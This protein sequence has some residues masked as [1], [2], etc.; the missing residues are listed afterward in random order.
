MGARDCGPQTNSGRDARVVAM[1]PDQPAPGQPA[2][3]QPAPGQPDAEPKL[4]G[5][6]PVHARLPPESRA[7]RSLTDRS[8]T[9]RP[10][11]DR[12]TPEEIR[13]DGA[14]VYPEPERGPRIW[15]RVVGVLI[16]LLGAGGAWV[17]Q[18]PGWLQD[19]VGGLFPGTASHDTETARIDALEARVARLE[20]RPPPTDVAPLVTSL[21]QRLDALEKRVDAAAPASADVRPLVARLDA[22][23]ARVA[24]SVAPSGRGVPPPAASAPT[25]VPVGPD[26]RPLVARI[27]ALEKTAAEHTVE[28]AKVDA[29]A[30]KI[31][32][33]ASH[34]PAAEFRGR[35]EEVTHQLNDLSASYTKQTEAADHA[36]RLARLD[37]AEIALASGHALG[38]IANAPPALARFATAAPPTE[39]ALRLRFGPIAQEA[40]KVSR[41]DTEG[42]PFLDRVLARLQDFKLIT[43]R[44][45]DNVLI[46]SS[47]AATIAHARLLLDAGDLAGAA[48]TVAALTGPPAE[49]M[50]PWLDDA[51]A[52]LAAREALA[53]LVIAADH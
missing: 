48:R 30:S 14:P 7:A 6:P 21:A 33:L 11:A 13:P 41:P 4:G 26:V 15:P 34:D 5:G 32:E 35:L 31:D 53:T 46:G 37:A 10:V 1:T 2:P 24:A 18:N 3:G 28:P 51:N 36:M 52:L 39:A 38:P 40:L 16:L 44:E 9:D 49:K 43:V 12:S 25:L 17:W 22:L 47:A 23:E 20:Q 8:A 29:M 19:T 27:E 50:A 42:K 45:G